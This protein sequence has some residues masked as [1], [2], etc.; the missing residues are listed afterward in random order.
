MPVYNVPGVEES[1][2]EV[3]K[4]H[5][6]GIYPAS[7]EEC[8]FQ[9]IQKE[10]SDYKGTIMLQLVFAVTNPESS[11]VVKAR[12]SILLPITAEGYTSP[13]DSE[14]KRK[15]LAKVKK[16]QIACGL[17]DMGTAIDNEA[18]MY[19]NLQVEVYEDDDATYGK[20]NKVK[21]Y[22]EA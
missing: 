11:V 22:L 6:A 20:Q 4:T 19:A 7:I 10:G 12:D 14:Q 9:E 21:D 2:G 18:F 8:K 13:M 3:F 5:A 15:A 17:E 1:D 16:L